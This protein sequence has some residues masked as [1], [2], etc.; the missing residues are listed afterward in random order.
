M[1]QVRATIRQRRPASRC[2]APVRVA[3]LPCRAGGVSRRA[4]KLTRTP[5]LIHH[6]CLVGGFLMP[7]SDRTVT[8][9][10]SAMTTISTTELHQR[11][12]DPH[13]TIVDV[14]PLVAYNGWHRSGVARG[15]HVPG[16]VAFPVAWIDTVD[17]IE[18]QRL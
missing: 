18:I 2:A 16:A 13:L 6:P 11:L 5:D 1:R 12:D 8:T 10:T 15:G 9:R 4:T 3:R 7:A 14:R 17:E